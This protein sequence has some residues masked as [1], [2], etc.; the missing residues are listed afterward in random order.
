MSCENHAAM[1][2]FDVVG[3]DERRRQPGRVA[4]LIDADDELRGF[5]RARLVSDG[6]AVIEAASGE[7]GLARLTPDVSVVLIDVGLPGLDGFSV[8]RSIRRVSRVPAIMMTAAS[9]ESD[10]VLGFELGADDYIVKPFLPREMLARVRTAA[11]RSVVDSTRSDGE[12]TRD[13]RT[14]LVVDQESREV[15]L[16]GE[17]ISL[18]AREFDLLAFFAASPRQVFTRDQLLRQV[19]NAEPGWINAAT[20]TEHI[21]RLRRVFESHP[22]CT[23]RIV[24]LRGVGYRFEVESG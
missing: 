8:L 6:F 5:V 21:H 16:D 14:G 12:R 18:T 17:L 23:A 7:E 4:L 15:R 2:R 10:R 24:T 19:W 20:V 9:D 13:D 1:C 11:R 3:M 22:N